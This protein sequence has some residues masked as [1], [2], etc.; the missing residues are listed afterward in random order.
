MGSRPKLELKGK[1][2]LRMK[3]SVYRCFH[4]LLIEMSMKLV[5]GRGDHSPFRIEIVA[6]G[7]KS[8]S[9][10]KFQNRN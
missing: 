4:I 8:E 2:T 10:L 1:W 7:T 6:L 5:W 3:W 9:S